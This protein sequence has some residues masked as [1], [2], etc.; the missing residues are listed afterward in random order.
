MVHAQ[1]RLGFC[2]GLQ[3]EEPQVLLLR[4]GEEVDINNE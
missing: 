4:A 2:V 3:S 1:P